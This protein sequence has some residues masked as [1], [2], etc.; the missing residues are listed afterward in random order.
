[1]T[2]EIYSKRPTWNAYQ[3]QTVSGFHVGENDNG[4][5]HFRLYDGTP[6]QLVDVVRRLNAYETLRLRMKEIC[7]VT[8]VGSDG[9][10]RMRKIALAAIQETSS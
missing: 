8:P 3:H 4:Q 9:A 10:A 5:P 1:M 7:N 6:Q 2:V